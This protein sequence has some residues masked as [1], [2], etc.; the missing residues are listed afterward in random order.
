MIDTKIVIPAKN[1]QVCF[2]MRQ[3]T[4]E[5]CDAHA[6]LLGISFTAAIIADAHPAFVKSVFDQL[7]R[8]YTRQTI[9]NMNAEQAFKFMGGDDD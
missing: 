3:T 8:H 4:G 2:Q 1:D 6:T 7:S 5:I 9:G